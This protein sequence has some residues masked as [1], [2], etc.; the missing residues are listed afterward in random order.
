MFVHQNQLDQLLPPEDYFSAATHQR[1]LE[2]LFRPGWHPLAALAQ[3]PKSG[4]Y[5]TLDLLGEPL[6]VRHAEGQIH[7]YLNVCPHRHCRLR[8]ERQGHDPALRCQYHGWEYQCDGRTARIPDARSFR[9]FDRENA[10]LVKFRTENWGDMTFVSLADAGPS[11]EAFLGPLHAEA[12][13]WLSPPFRFAWAWSRDYPANWKV[14]VENTLESYHIHCLHK[15]TLGRMPTE[16]ECTHLLEEEFTTF[17]TPETIG[18]ISRMQNLLVRSLGGVIRNIYTHHHVHPHLW[19]ISMDVM[20]MV[21]TIEPLSANSSRHRVWIY[22]LDSVRRNPWAWLV[23]RCLRWI[24]IDTA[25]KILL[26]D[27]G[28]FPEIQQGLEKSRFRGCLGTREERVHAFQRF[29][30]SRVT[31]SRP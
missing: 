8:G 23:Q 24:V 28:I 25:R 7:A 5:L 14:V 30:R 19:V 22:T 27:A 9:P 29:V 15:Q 21:Q 20:R 10:Q 26:E 17:H 6:L 1:E 3:L 31:S 18:W 13:Q 11:L 2:V 16:E 4:D 12:A